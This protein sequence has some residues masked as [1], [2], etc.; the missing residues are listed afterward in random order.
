MPRY[1][2]VAP[3]FTPLDYKTRIAPLEQYKEEYDKRMDAL[4]EQGVLADAIGGLIDENQDPELARTY[5]DYNDKMVSTAQNLLQTGDLGSS[6]R[7]LGELRRDYANKLVPIQQ[8]YNSRAEAGKTYQSIIAKDPSYRGNN[9]VDD[10]LSAYMN[11]KMPDQFGISGDKV[12]A[13]G[14]ADAK[15]QMT[16]IRQVVRDWG[17]DKRLNGQFFSEAYANGYDG[18]Q[19]SE[20]LAKLAGKDLRDIATQEGIGEITDAFGYIQDSLKRL[21][22][23][24]NV[25]KLKNES[26]QKD[27]MNSA[28]NG[29][30][31]GMTYEYKE[32]FKENSTI[33]TDYQKKYLEYLGNKPTGRTGSGSS[34]GSPAEG[35]VVIDNKGK[36]FGD[37]ETKAQATKDASSI[38]GQDKPKKRLTPKSINKENIQSE[39]SPQTIEALFNRYRLSINDDGTIDEDMRRQLLAKELAKFIKENNIN[40][41]TSDRKLLNKDGS[42]KKWIAGTTVA[43]HYRAKT[44]EDG[45]DQSDED[46]DVWSNPTD[47]K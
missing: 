46:S 10:P 45:E 31:A 39:L 25:G 21:Y 16:R 28:L 4:D 40:I 5:K 41:S 35:T 11:G 7:A 6:R 44:T 34:S 18:K 12:Y 19:V 36:I 3:T 9:P 32:N 47:K 14:M 2:A 30:L 42:V 20:A 15:A 23:S 1:T 13:E 33:M 8:A 26:Y 17:L 38:I 27:I 37:Y 22:E 24:N 29:I 43:E